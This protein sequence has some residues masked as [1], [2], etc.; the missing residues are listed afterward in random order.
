VRASGHPQH[1]ERGPHFELPEQ[2][3]QRVRLATEGGSR[4]APVRGTHAPADELMPILEVDAQQQCLAILHGVH[5]PPEVGIG[6][7]DGVR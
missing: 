4:F 7:V 6:D 3:K 1:E 5:R 2:V